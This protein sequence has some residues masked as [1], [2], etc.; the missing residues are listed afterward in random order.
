MQQERKIADY[1][2]VNCL[3]TGHLFTDSTFW[4]I[5]ISAFL[6]KHANIN[7]SPSFDC[8]RRFFTSR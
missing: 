5:A 2:T 3:V 6:E 1:I 4:E 7:N 8:S